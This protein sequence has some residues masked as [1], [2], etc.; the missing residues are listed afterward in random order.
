MRM[1]IRKP[2]AVTL[3]VGAIINVGLDPLLMFGIPGWFSGMGIAG[4]AW[5]TVSIQLVSLHLY[6]F[7]ACIVVVF[8]RSVIGTHGDQSGRRFERFFYIAIP[9][10]LSM[11][12][13]AVGIFVINA[14]LKEF[15]T[16]VMAVYGVG[17]RIEQIV[18]LP[19]IGLSIASAAIIAQN[20]GAK[21][22]T[23]VREAYKLSLWYGS[24]VLI[25]MAIII[26]LVS[27]R[28]Y[29]LFITSENPEIAAEIVRL[30]REYTTVILGLFWGYIFL[31]IT[32]SALQS[33]KRPMFGLWMGLFR[34]VILP[35]VA[36][37]LVLRSGGNYLDIWWS[38]FGI[39]WFSAI[40]AIVYGMRVFRKLEKN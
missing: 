20:N 14:F 23:R 36:F 11:I 39:V 8:S 22:F 3:I 26:W 34:Q 21:N 18:L 17:T 16:N 33:V 40:I 27:D 28:L 19:V 5:A 25:P 9:A 12:F 35:I 32:I 29:P 24:L 15:G 4:V 2:T 13:V 31:F 10:S 30:G 7:S 6:D 1:E 37:T 38:I